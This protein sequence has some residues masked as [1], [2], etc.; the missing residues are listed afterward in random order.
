MAGRPS[1]TRHR[2]AATPVICN[3]DECAELDLMHPGEGRQ[4]LLTIP[5]ARRRAAPSRPANPASPGQQ[6]AAS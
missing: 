6:A 5:V 4:L 3:C 1:I 2:A